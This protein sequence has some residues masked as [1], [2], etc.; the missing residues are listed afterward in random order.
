LYTSPNIIRVINSTRIWVGHV[1]CMGEMRNE[2]NALVR[3]PE[4]KRPC[5]RP[6]HRW[7]DY[8]KMDLWEI[9]WEDVDWMHLA[10]DRD[11]GKPCV[12]GNESSAFI[13]GREF[14]FFSRRT[15]LHEVS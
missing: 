9:G 12:Y 14:L 15:L 6:R 10:E 2:Y 5:K 7:E 3:K 8:V 1:A 11:H 13:K 4:G